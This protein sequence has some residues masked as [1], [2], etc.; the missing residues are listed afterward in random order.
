M[1]LSTSPIKCIWFRSIK[2][3]VKLWWPS[4]LPHEQLWSHESWKLDKYWW[5][6]T[7]LIVFYHF[8]HHV[9]YLIYI[10]Y[11]LTGYNCTLCPFKANQSSKLKVHFRSHTKEKPYKCEHC[12]YSTAY[13][14]HLKVH[15]RTHT[16]EKPYKC[17]RC[18]FRCNYLNVLKDHERTHK[19]EKPFECSTSTCS[20]KCATKTQLKRHIRTHTGEKPFS[21]TKCTQH[22]KWKSCLKAHKC[23]NVSAAPSVRNISNGKVAWRPI[24]AKTFQLYQV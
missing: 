5:S 15:Q 1:F 11:H 9:H 3:N 14:N 10:S 8:F 23:K 6:R 16:N 19:R 2:S 21:C 12:L 4:L 13:Q 24:N 18:C 20:Y 17:R 7:V 22:F